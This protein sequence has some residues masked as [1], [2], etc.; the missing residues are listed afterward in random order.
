MICLVRMR[1]GE[2]DR[3]KTSCSSDLEKL[4]QIVACWT[5]NLMAPNSTGKEGAERTTWLRKNSTGL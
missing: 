5:L 3:M 2:G 1:K 4:W